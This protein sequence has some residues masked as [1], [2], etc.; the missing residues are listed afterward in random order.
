ML[1]HVDQNTAVHFRQDPLVAQ[2]TL[3]AHSIVL[4]LATG[5]R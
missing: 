5:V 4:Q 3:H 1:A 2:S